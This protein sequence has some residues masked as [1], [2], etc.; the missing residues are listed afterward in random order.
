MNRGFWLEWRYA[1]RRLR[2]IPVF[3]TGVVVL[4]GVALGGTVAVGTAA[5]QLFFKP[6]PYAQPEQLVEFSSIAHSM[7]GFNLGISPGMLQEL[8]NDGSLG[9]LSAFAE[10]DTVTGDNSQSWRLAE[11]S[12]NLTAMLRVKPLLGRSFSV[13]DTLA[14]APVALLSEQVWRTRFSALPD[15]LGREIRIE[16]RYLTIIGVLPQRFSI[17]TPDTEVWVPLVF[18]PALLEPN[19]ISNF[20][21]LDV[22]GRLPAGMSAEIAQQQLR[23]RF[24]DDPRLAGM[25][26]ITGLEFA[27]QPLQQ[28]WTSRH[29]PVLVILATAILLV[30]LA[31]ALNLAG[32]WMSRTLGR[33]HEMA[34]QAALGGSHW[35]GMRLFIMEYLLLGV[36]GAALAL[37]L[38]PLALSWLA[39]LNVLDSELPIR[40][41][42]GPAAV[43]L[44]AAF[45]VLSALPVLVAV[46]WQARRI[47]KHA[48]MQLVSGG[49]SANASGVRGR[50]TLIVVQLAVAM[51]LL[52][53]VSLLLQSWQALLNENLGF[54]SQ[55]LVMASIGLDAS[56][57]PDEA[58]I[59]RIN[60]NLRAAIDTLAGVPGVESVTFASVAPFSGSETVSTYRMPDQPEIDHGA[61]T[62]QVAVNYFQTLGIPIRS[63]RAFAGQDESDGSNA[64]M[65]DQQFAAQHFPDGGAVGEYIEYQNG[66]DTRLLEIIG[67]TDT[68]KHSSPD[69]QL[70]YPSIYFPTRLPYRS[71]HVLV[72]TDLPPDTL[73]RQIQATLAQQLGTDNVSR[74]SSMQSLVRRAV[75]ER[76]PQLI[77]LTVFAGITVLLAAVGIYALLS[78]AV[79]QRTAEFGV[80]LAVGANAWRI[81]RLVLNSGLRLLVPGV[82]LGL[83]GAM[84]GGHLIADQLYSVTIINPASWSTVA[85]VLIAIVLLAGLW[86]SE[87]AARTAPTEA[88]RYE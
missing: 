37:L 14:D 84:L 70:G 59:N 58:E 72:S 24:A 85:G 62:R 48:A 71:A 65:V 18:E 40:V 42:L 20:T 34:I 10:A 51:S 31:A 8:R 44:A 17:P 50:N 33:G 68:V 63:G 26:D 28:A 43:V 38:T 13:E 67:V 3:C 45:L 47:Q 83:A 60:E 29:R 23:A 15:V 6:L 75:R 76:E 1:L 41:A 25:V 16:D 78:Y 66:E 21:G 53:T 81:R 36:A 2:K 46:W 4:L 55:R 7:N 11:L 39:E 82:L 52:V 87:Q 88:L 49:Q 12:D 32:L 27:V 80:R 64:V 22:L 54:A 57:D 19:N 30:L 73:T 77:L 35:N 79:K 9:E 69:E 61:R 86:P 74:V 56:E 5:Y